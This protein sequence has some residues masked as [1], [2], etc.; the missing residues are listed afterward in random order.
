MPQPVVA[1][2]DIGKTNKKLFLFNE[3]YRIVFEKSIH[4]DE[5]VDEDGDP[6]EDMNSLRNF[7]LEGI[8]LVLDS[9]DFQVRAIN[10]S[11][12]GASF[13]YIDEAGK[14]VAPLYNYLKPYPPAL[15]KRFYDTY[16]GEK[17]FSFQTASPVLGSLNSGMQL[18][19]M[20]HEKPDV[21]SRISYALHLPQYLSYIL[22]GKAYSE[23]T[24]IGCHTN[25]WHFQN[26]DYHYW[27]KQEGILDKLP[28]I[29][30][31]DM[32]VQPSGYSHSVGI[33]LH[34]SS[35]ALIPY[36]VSYADPFV[37][38]STGTW[39]ISLNP[40]NAAPLT[41]DELECDCLSYLQYRGAPV[42]ASRLF[43]GHNH[44]EQVERIAAHFN[45][46]KE[47]Y[48][49]LDF[50]KDILKKTDI[51]FDPKANSKTILKDL[52]FASRDLSEF[53]NDSEA[54]HQLI[55]DLVVQQYVSTQMII[56]GTSV[57]K[58]FVDGG[59]SNNSVYMNLLASSF[60]TMDVYASSVPQATA[61]GAALAIHDAWN[62]Q[63]FPPNI[64]EL[65]SF[66]PQVDI[67]L[68]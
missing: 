54:Y 49:K 37:L 56:R 16:G 52:R 45:Q 33:G 44:E 9:S 30:P 6:C 42:K 46:K 40:F 20:K 65:K 26:M 38:I 14:T 28:E 3:S 64:I 15:L 59:F 8:A 41:K 19:R 48:F 32:L 29:T 66:K 58:I 22:T 5:T 34:D 61:I 4:F 36:L 35:A 27:V 17:L 53:E 55:F 62:S 31:S 43:A 23:I 39:A 68:R 25:L 13:V 67:T 18:Y 2:F 1:I 12:Y 21:F 50:D 47:K 7:I 60:P 11:A 10:F 51:S 57:K 24:S 63:T